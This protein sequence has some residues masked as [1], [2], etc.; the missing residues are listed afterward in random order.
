MDKQELTLDQIAEIA[1]KLKRKPSAGKGRPKI[2][3]EPN[4]QQFGPIR[5]GPAT[6]IVCTTCTRMFS[7]KENPVRYGI[8]P[9]HAKRHLADHRMGR[10][11]RPVEPE[12]K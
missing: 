4:G 10:I 12:E 3:R 6:W 7:S 1:P 5:K 9:R 11:R 8:R 2:L